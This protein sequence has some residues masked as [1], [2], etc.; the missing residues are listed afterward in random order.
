MY[1]IAI[2]RSA[3]SPPISERYSSRSREVSDRKRATRIIGSQSPDGS[4]KLRPNSNRTNAAAEAAERMP[5]R[6]LDAEREPHVRDTTVLKRALAPDASST[7]T[8]SFPHRKIIW[9]RR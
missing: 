6:E 3:T 5:M 2:L 4:R 7:A 9:R 8:D 1:L